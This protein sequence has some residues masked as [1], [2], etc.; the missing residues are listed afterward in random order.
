MVLNR[1]IIPQKAGQL[2]NLPRPRNQATQQP[3][4][5]HS[6]QH[7]RA[8]R[9]G[10]PLVPPDSPADPRPPFLLERVQGQGCF[11]AVHRAVLLVRSRHRHRHRHRNRRRSRRRRRPRRGGAAAAGAS[12]R[13]GGLLTNK[14]QT[15]RVNQSRVKYQGYVRIAPPVYKLRRNIVYRINRLDYFV[16]KNRDKN[17]TCAEG[18]KE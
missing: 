10:V 13:V 9:V 7:T 3:S 12:R 4:R 17:R 15:S 8:P 1:H 11:V 16:K 18:A 5:A 14:H 6:T 2:I